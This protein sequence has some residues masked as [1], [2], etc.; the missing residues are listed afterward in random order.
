MANANDPKASSAPGKTAAAP[1]GAVPL[2]ATA[3]ALDRRYGFIEHIV[4]LNTPGPQG[5]ELVFLSAEEEDSL[6][7]NPAGFLAKHWGCPSERDYLE[8][9]ESDFSVQC[10]SMTKRGKRCR[11]Q[12]AACG[13]VEF[14]MW[15]AFRGEYCPVHGGG[16]ADDNRRKWKSLEQQRKP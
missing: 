13:R 7:Q 4:T 10:A 6:V 12:V 15:L 5:A 16:S 9:L 1:T 11:G 2:R 14:A 3:G 8:W